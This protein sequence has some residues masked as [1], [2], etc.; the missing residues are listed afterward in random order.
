[1]RMEIETVRADG[2]DTQW[3]NGTWHVFMQQFT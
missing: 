2:R 1:M 3:T